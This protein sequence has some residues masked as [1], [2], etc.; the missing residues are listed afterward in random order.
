M[1]CITHNE[2]QNVSKI[3]FIVVGCQ[4]RF[5]IPKIQESDNDLHMVP[6]TVAEPKRTQG[7]E[8]AARSI[9]R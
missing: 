1:K 7:L 8:I 2:T 6:H 5:A 9:K 3:G 4:P